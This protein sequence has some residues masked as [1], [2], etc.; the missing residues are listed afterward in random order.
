MRHKASNVDLRLPFGAPYPALLP[1]AGSAPPRIN[2]A[3]SL[4]HP[5][6]DHAPQ[7]ADRCQR[8]REQGVGRLA[9]QNRD[10]DQDA[11]GDEADAVRPAEDEGLAGEAR[12]EPEE[13]EAGEDGELD[14]ARALDP[15]A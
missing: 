4:D 2:P 10:P 9:A 8:C 5:D 14:P 15:R 12:R 7:R 3:L 6:A 13:A 11:Q 1:V